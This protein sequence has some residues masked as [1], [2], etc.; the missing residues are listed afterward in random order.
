MATGVP[1]RSKRPARG[2]M[3]SAPQKAAMPPVMCT[4]PY[5]RVK[6]RRERRGLGDRVGCGGRERVLTVGVRL[7][8]ESG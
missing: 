7:G 8:L 4:T 5:E 6:A 3:I 1:S 2:P